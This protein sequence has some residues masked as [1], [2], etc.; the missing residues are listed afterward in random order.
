[1]PSDYLDDSL[2]ED[3]RD[4]K[5]DG[6]LPTSYPSFYQRDHEVERVFSAEGGVRMERS[7]ILAGFQRAASPW[8]LFSSEIAKNQ[9]SF[10]AGKRTGS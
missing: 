2:D 10:L 6:P 4:A 1:V 8:R 7:G 5:K 9:L 3:T